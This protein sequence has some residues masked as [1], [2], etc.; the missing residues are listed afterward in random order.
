MTAK[1]MI[2]LPDELKSAITEFNL[3]HPYETL[4]ISQIAQKA[5]FEKIMAIDPDIFRITVKTQVIESKVLIIE[6][7]TQ[8][9]SSQKTCAYCKNPFTAI[10]PRAKFCS[11]KCKSADYRT[12]KNSMIN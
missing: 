1:M 2:S 11:G 12:R 6:N 5:I 7:G 8:A 10:N 4:N 3:K 9:D